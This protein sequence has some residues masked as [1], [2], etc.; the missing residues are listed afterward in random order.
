MAFNLSKTSSEHIQVPEN[1]QKNTFWE[2]LNQNYLT[3]NIKL[4]LTL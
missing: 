3:N 2:S 4:F 1:L